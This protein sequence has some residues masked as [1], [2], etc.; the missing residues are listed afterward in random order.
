M[1]KRVIPTQVQKTRDEIETP[2][3]E[4]PQCCNCSRKEKTTPKT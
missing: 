3:K 4:P 2:R 1:S